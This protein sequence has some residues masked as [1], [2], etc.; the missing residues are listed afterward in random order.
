MSDGA[1]RRTQVANGQ[2]RAYIRAKEPA[3]IYDRRT[4]SSRRRA[5]MITRMDRSTHRHEHAA[6]VL[7]SLHPPRL[8]DVHSRREFGLAR[9]RALIQARRP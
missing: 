4:K 6:Q 8:R 3:V 1:I 7:R 9:V 5:G 2:N